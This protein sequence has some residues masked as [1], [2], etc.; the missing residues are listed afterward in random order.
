MVGTIRASNEA[1]WFVMEHYRNN[2]Q[3]TRASV[4]DYLNNLFPRYDYSGRWKENSIPVLQEHA[5]DPRWTLNNPPPR[6]WYSAQI[7]RGNQI[8]ARRANQAQ[9]QSNKYQ[10]RQ[11]ANISPDRQRLRP[12]VCSPWQPKNPHGLSQNVFNDSEQGEEGT[13]RT[14]PQA[15]IAAEY[16]PDVSLVG[17]VPYRQYSF[18][19]DS[20]RPQ[21]QLLNNMSKLVNTPPPRIPI[22]S[23]I[24]NFSDPNLQQHDLFGFQQFPTGGPLS[25][26][27]THQV[28]AHCPLNTAM[29]QGLQRSSV[30][31][32]HRQLPPPSE[33]SPKPSSSQATNLTRTINFIDATGHAM[34]NSKPISDNM[35]ANLSKLLLTIKYSQENGDT[36]HPDIEI[37][38]PL[39]KRVVG[40]Y[41]Q[42]FLSKLQDGSSKDI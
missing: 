15:S 39:L 42:Y 37:R 24:S 13:I 21:N 16:I 14:Q 32:Q 36:V 17:E 31:Y 30:A 4:A 35:L 38:V 6:G 19:P 18:F 12:N 25:R 41:E 33:P 1:I 5:A 22:S 23:V 9:K 2:P 20:C 7:T 8:A 26:T 11:T 34:N 28:H 27:S 29:T 3:A 40:H 10:S